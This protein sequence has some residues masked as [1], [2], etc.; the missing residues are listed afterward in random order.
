MFYFSHISRPTREI[1]YSLSVLTQLVH[2]KLYKK[3]LYL[4]VEWRPVAHSDAAAAPF[5]TLVE[6]IGNVGILDFRLSLL[7]RD[8]ENWTVEFPSNRCLYTGLII[9]GVSLR[10]SYFLGKKTNKWINTT[11]NPSYGNFMKEINVPLLYLLS[12]V[13]YWRFLFSRSPLTLSLSRLRER[14]NGKREI[15]NKGQRTTSSST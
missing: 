10:F 7:E 11:G 8:S 9:H 5:W 1:S 3:A 15:A 6:W 13:V 4:V 12:F 2:P 14:R